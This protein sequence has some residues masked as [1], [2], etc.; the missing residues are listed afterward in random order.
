MPARKKS[1]GGA[2]TAATPNAANEEEG[3]LGIDQF[4]LPKSVVA[5][6]AKSA[7][8][9][10]VK[11]Q[12]E[13]PLALVKG[14]TVFINYLAALAHD[15]AQE[16]NQKTITA[17]HVL[18]AV[19]QLGWQDEGEELS[20]H[21]KRELKAFRKIAEQKKNGTYVAPTKPRTA[22]P[23][24]ITNDDD[25]EMGT[26]QGDESDGE[27]EEEGVEEYV[28]V[29][30]AANDEGDD[31]DGDDGVEEPAGAPQVPLDD[32]EDDDDGQNQA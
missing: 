26:L 3:G 4:E 31:N 30:G 22:A 10:E 18:E 21:L 27:R 7:V 14:S 12:K 32:V 20:K 29:E 2:H 24:K 13:V 1:I 19:K 15:L 23:P 28:E 17:V 25:A 9:P 8:A 5:R 11:L 6:L 16:K